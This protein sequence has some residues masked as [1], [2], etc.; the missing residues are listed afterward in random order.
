MYSWLSLLFFP[1]NLSPPPSLSH[2]NYLQLHSYG[3]LG[4]TTTK[5]RPLESFSTGFFHSILTSNFVSKSH[6]LCLQN[7]SWL[8]TM[9]DWIGPNESSPWEQLENLDEIQKNI[10]LKALYGF[11]GSQDLKSHNPRIKRMAEQ[12]YLPSKPRLP[13]R[14]C[15]PG[16]REAEQRAVIR[17]LVVLGDK[18]WSTRSARW[19]GPDSQ[20]RVLNDNMQEIRGNQK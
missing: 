10:C 4:T 7:I 13:M 12:W 9:M 2:F 3:F 11:Q 14:Q 19:M 16:I 8:P 18:N 1:P 15:W 6:S 5:T 20:L 17:N